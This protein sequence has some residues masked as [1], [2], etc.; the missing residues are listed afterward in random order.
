[1]ETSGTLRLKGKSEEM[2]KSKGEPG[3]PSVMDASE[4]RTQEKW[5]GVGGGQ[6]LEQQNDHQDKD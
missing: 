4:G 1:M 3:N 5:V 6:N 2:H